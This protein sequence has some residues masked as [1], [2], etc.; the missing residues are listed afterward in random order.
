[1]GWIYDLMAVAYTFMWFMFGRS[2]GIYSA[3]KRFHTPA[4]PSYCTRPYHRCGQEGAGPCNGYPDPAYP[5]SMQE[6][7]Y[8]EELDDES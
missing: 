5:F 7:A 3:R 4:S 6:G 8:E 2:S 1:M